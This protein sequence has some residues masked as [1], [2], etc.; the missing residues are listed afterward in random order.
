MELD[1]VERALRLG[2]PIDTGALPVDRQVRHLL[3]IA[4]ANA[5][6]GRREQ[7]LDLIL[8]AEARAPEQVRNHAL[9]RDLI[10]RWVRAGRGGPRP[11]LEEGADIRPVQAR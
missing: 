2:E 10:V 4:R 9:A 7:A 5:E 11:A 3:G 1:D 8:A 6:R